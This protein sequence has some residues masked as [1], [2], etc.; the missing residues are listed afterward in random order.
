MKKLKMFFVALMMLAGVTAYAQITVKGIVTDASTG[1]GVPFAS[2]MQK[3]SMNGVS[4]NAE[5]AY[6]IQIPG[7]GVIVVSSIGYKDQ[8]VAVEGRS[9]IN[10]VLAP[11]SEMLNETIVVAFG[12]ATKESFTGSAKVVGSNEIATSQ[13]SNA[14]QALNGKVAGVQMTS[15]TGAP[16][17]DGTAIR[18]RG[19]SSINAGQSPL[20]ILDGSPFDGSMKDINPN[21]IESMTVLK[22]AASNAL[23]GAR[24]ANGVI[25]ITT[26][27][28]DGKEAVV[29]FDAKIGVNSRGIQDYDYINT[30]SAY[31]EAHYKALYNSYV[32]S[33]LS[34]FEA[35]EKAN[36]NVAG[37]MES[38]GLGYQVYTVPSGQYFIGTNGRLNPKA[39]LG[40]YVTYKDE[41]Y[42]LTPD[43]WTNEA[44]RNSI[45]QE[46]N[47]SVSG[48]SDKGNFYLSTGYLNNKGI[49]EKT[50]FARFTTRLK[51]DY[52][53]KKWLKVGANASYTK[54]E[55]NLSD[56]DGVSNSSANIFALTT[57]IAPIY[58]LYIRDKD[59]NIKKDSNGYTVYDYG[60]K[61]NAGLERPNFTGTNAIGDHMLNVNGSEGNAINVNGFADF[62]FLKDFKFTLNAGTNVTERRSTSLTNAFYG[63]YKASNGII[64][65]SHVRGFSYNFQQ[66]LNWHHKFGKNDV[67]IMVGH[68]NYEYDYAYLYAYKSNMFSPDNLELAGAVEAGSMNSYTTTY[69][70]E[71]YFGRAQYNFDEKLFASAS[72]RRDASSR[73][74][75]DYRWGNFWSLGGAWIMSK[76]SWFNASWIDMLKFKASYGSQGNDSIGNYLYTDTYDIINA[77]G[78][79]ATVLSSKGNKE[80]TWET[81]GNFNAGVEFELF[82]NRLSGSAEGFYRKTTDMLSWF[83]VPPSLG[84]SGYYA[85]V[86]DMRN[87]GIE[88]DITAVPVKTQNF[89]WELNFNV[90]L[91]RNKITKLDASR[92][93]TKTSEGVEGYQSG[94]YFYGEGIPIYTY[95]TK[96]YAGVDKSTGQSMWYK[97]VEVNGTK[98]KV[99]TTAYSE[100]TDYLCGNPIPFAFGGFGTTFEAY[101][102]DLSINFTY[103]LGGLINDSGYALAM[104]SPI[105][106]TLGKNFH[107]DIYKAWTPENTETDVPR[108]Q[109]GDNYTG[110]ASDR[111]LT[112]GSF[113][114]LQ[115]INLGYTLPKK[116]TKKAGIEKLRVYAACENVWLW[117]ARTGLDPRLSFTGSN[118]ATTYSIVRTVSGGINL[119]F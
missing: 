10:I 75:P 70:N 91:L 118:N 112:S 45:R 89:N 72:Y 15:S 115:N 88:L 12:T 44:I 93:T 65:K 2:V 71:G 47:V 100:A 105:S 46:Y 66:I 1:E 69:N 19:F 59:G 56:E 86:G 119:T 84:Y 114:N 60:T 53:A 41:T 55:S 74:H 39:T 33:G 82:K 73:F 9:S 103:Q 34:A 77:A 13:V 28:S 6:S 24:G 57:Q 7:D 64:N 22:D 113:L 51:A 8:E 21:D 48:G 61:D 85:N 102:F 99:P 111:W 108:F 11:D 14:V 117:S 17:D 96:Q 30:P 16:G 81:N 32:N 26:K 63:T 101:G 95:Y 107:K 78:A 18:V 52:Q 20:I 106:S 27:K 50:D 25:M 110:S 35:H 58:P 97:D 92:K 37:P 83:S 40:N 23:Y 98:M 49:V 42:Y 43:N 80:I 62:T 68:E 79:V 5:G 31:Y 94:G 3:G 87:L 90:T 109:Y 116:I 29:K 54:S 104:A 36:T 76:E 38:G 4:T 67:E